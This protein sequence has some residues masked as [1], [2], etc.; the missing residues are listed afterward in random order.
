MST[1]DVEGRIDLGRE[2]GVVLGSQGSQICANR[3]LKNQLAFQ[4][5]L[6]SM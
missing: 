4:K 1:V 5:S 2:H 6:R 3:T